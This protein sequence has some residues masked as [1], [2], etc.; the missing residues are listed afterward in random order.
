MQHYSLVF[1][2]TS[3]SRRSMRINNPNTDLPLEDIETAIGQMIT[4]DIFDQER[5]GL[6]SLSRMELSTIERKVIL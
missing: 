1:N 5:G 2:T 4:N 3:G 6:E